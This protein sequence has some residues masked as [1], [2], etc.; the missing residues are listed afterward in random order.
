MPCLEIDLGLN[1]SAHHLD[2]RN[3]LFTWGEVAFDA[4]VMNDFIAGYLGAAA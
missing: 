4:D 1:R 3:G 2:E